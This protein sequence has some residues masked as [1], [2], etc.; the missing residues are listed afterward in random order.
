MTTAAT[1]A[2]VAGD[3][4]SGVRP[5]LAVVASHPVQYQAPWYR[6]LSA[7]VDLHVF[8]AHRM[9]AADHARA[10]FDVEFEWDTPVLEGYSSSW[11]ENVASRPGVDRFRGCNTPG[12]APAIARGGFDAVVVNG[13]HLL[14]YWQAIR[15]ARRAGVPV[16]VRGDSQLPTARGSLRRSVKRVVYPQLLKAF[17]A[18][19]AVGDR[20]E[21]YY[22]HYGVP[23][24]RIYRSPHCVDNAF[25]ARAA[26]AARAGANGVRRALGIPDEAIVF[27][28]VGKFIEKKRPFDF[29]AALDAVG[30][31]HPAAWGLLVGDGPLRRAMDAHR[32]RYDTRCTMIGFLNQQR[33]AAGY[34]AAD[35]LVLPSNGD[36][37]WGLVVNEAMACGVPA[38]VSDQVGC[39]PDLVVPGETGFVFPCGDAA[40]LADRMR[41]FLEDRAL[42]A[43]MRPRVLE[44][45]ARYSPREA[46]AGVVG[47]MTGRMRRGAAADR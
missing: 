39:G 27:A 10:G 43:A 32:R 45:V 9:A 5:R 30:R 20:N 15:A 42:G 7:M 4:Q 46:A 37:T 2:I 41:R 13:W 23:A 26:A 33:I 24:A 31:A 3:P 28:F 16:M 12:I 34:A 36:E 1:A 17:D 40:A 8:F 44:R 29:L 25:F 47:A 21:A 18:Y 14:A 35:V 38:I 22:R 11:L 19:L 6:A